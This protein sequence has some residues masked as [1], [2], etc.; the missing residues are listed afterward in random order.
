MKRRTKRLLVLFLLGFLATAG[1]VRAYYPDIWE[2]TGRSIEE[3]PLVSETIK[4]GEQKTKELETVLGNQVKQTQQRVE[5]GNLPVE[6]IVEKVLH[7]SQLVQEIQTRVET[8]VT[9]KT[10]EIRDLPEEAVDQV[11]KEVKKELHQQM[12]EE[13]LS[14]D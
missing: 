4:T 11:K 3:L 13:W 9:E 2:K 8:T 14:E 6:S 5:T 1:I 10:Q 7:D 12:C